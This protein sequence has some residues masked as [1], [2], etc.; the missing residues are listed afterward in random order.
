MV[1]IG[2]VYIIT[3]VSIMASKMTIPREGHL[4]AVLHVF[5]V[6]RQTYNPRMVFDPTYPVIEMNDFK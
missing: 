5:V 4:E 3:K 2:R 1:E 6:I